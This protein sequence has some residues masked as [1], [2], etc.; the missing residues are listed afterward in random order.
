MPVALTACLRYGLV[1]RS[2]TYLDR[3]AALREASGN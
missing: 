2:T 3:E 1:T